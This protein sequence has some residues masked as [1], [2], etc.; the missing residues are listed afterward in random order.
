MRDKPYFSVRTG[1][2]PTGGRL[3]LDGLRRL[4]LSAYYQLA[5]DD[6]FQEFFGYECVDE[7]RVIGITGEDIEAFFF[8]KL[9]K[10]GL[11]PLNE[12]INHFSEDDLFDVIELLHD[13]ASKGVDGQYHSWG[14]CGWHYNT[15]DRKAGQNEFR[16]QLNEVLSTYGP[17]YRLTGDG[18]I[19]A[20]PPEGLGDLEEATDPPGD[21]DAIKAKVRVARDKFR[22][23]GS[24]LEERRDAVRDLADVLEFLRPQAKAVLKSKDE[25]DLFNLANNF[26]IRHHNAEQKTDYDPAIW[27]SWAFYYYLDTIHAV[28][29]LIERGKARI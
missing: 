8:R 15:F 11:W 27:L 1:K 13:C 7:G 14:N 3:D 21:P 22:R 29:R 9:Q 2:H 18:E 28:T 17:G 5:T 20:I 19:I 4:V 25:A 26:G 24:T 16:I 23:R 10:E 6:Y 12:V